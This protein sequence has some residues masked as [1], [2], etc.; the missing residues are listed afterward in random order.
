VEEKEEE[1]SAVLLAVFNDYEAADRVRLELFRDGF[2]TDRVDL[3][4]A[5]DPGR[6]GCQPAELPRGKFIQYF[7]TLFKSDGDREYVANLAERLH[8]GAAVVTVHPRG[9]IE[10]SRA[11][12]IIESGSPAEVAHR[13]LGHQALERAAASSEQP[14]IRHVLLEKSDAHCIYCRLFESTHHAH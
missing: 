7:G 11:A 14:W 5:C 3:T 6:A 1:M 4:A 8:S 2:P 13:D 12:R 10:T 9:T